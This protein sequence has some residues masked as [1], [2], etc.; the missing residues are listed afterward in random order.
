[1]IEQLATQLGAFRPPFSARRTLPR[2]R[3]RGCANLRACCCTAV[4]ADEVRAAAADQ[5]R[6][7]TTEAAA[8]ETAA[9]ICQGPPDIRRL[10][11]LREEAIAAAVLQRHVQRH[12]GRSRSR[13]AKQTIE[14]STNR[15]AQLALDME[16]EAGLNKDA[17][18]TIE[19]LE[20][21]RD[22][23]RRKCRA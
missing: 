3:R 18:E 14:V 12:A 8:F 19:R 17:G 2:H 6:T 20:W 7:R 10:P 4:E 22:Y 15:I 5:L 11:A 21:K 16:R 1:V 23:K 13:G 9:S